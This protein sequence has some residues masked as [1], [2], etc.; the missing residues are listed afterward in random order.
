M[1]AGPLGAGAP[2]WHQTAFKV[3]EPALVK[4][5]FLTTSL[6]HCV[7]FLFFCSARGRLLLLF[8]HLRHTTHSHILTHTRAHTHI[9]LSHTLSHTTLSHNTVSHQNCHTTLSHTHTQLCYMLLE[10]GRRGIQSS[11]VSIAGVAFTA[12]AGVDRLGLK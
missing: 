4:L 8:R 7:G 2:T 3:M 10:S 1:K 5:K 12:V 11:W 9:Q 6:C